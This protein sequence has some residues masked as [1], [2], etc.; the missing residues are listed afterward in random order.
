MKSCHSA[1]SS[2]EN[3]SSKVSIVSLATEKQKRVTAQS[4]LCV[5]K[6][7]AKTKSIL[8]KAVAE[9][10]EPDAMDL[11][12]VLVNHMTTPVGAAV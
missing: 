4:K 9:A 6:H 7:C 3:A 2:A 1:K 8:A 11:A 10:L 5:P 12:S